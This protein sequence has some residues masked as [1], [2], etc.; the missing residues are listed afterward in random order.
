MHAIQVMTLRLGGSTA[1]PPGVSTVTA[2]AR[3]PPAPPDSE[4]LRLPPVTVLQV[5]SC[6]GVTV[7][8]VRLAPSQR[9]ARVTSL[10]VTPARAGLPAE[11]IVAADAADPGLSL[12]V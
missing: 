1:G 6:R 3:A 4:S 10:D 7:T 5:G 2:L 9:G 8:S 12:T 11:H